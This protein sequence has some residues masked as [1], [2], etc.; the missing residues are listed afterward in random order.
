VL[1]LKRYERHNA[2]SSPITKPARSTFTPFSSFNSAA[3]EHD[4]AELL[5]WASASSPREI[6][7]MLLTTRRRWSINGS[8]RATGRRR[9]RDQRFITRPIAGFYGL[10]IWPRRA[11]NDQC[12]F[13]GG[14][15]AS[16]F[17][18]R[19]ALRVSIGWPRWTA[20]A[21][22]RVM[23]LQR[24]HNDL[25]LLSSVTHPVAVD[26]DPLLHEHASAQDGRHDL[27]PEAK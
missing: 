4:P 21:V 11:G 14:R 23:V 24:L 10:R 9:D 13:T 16:V 20:L 27:A 2:A 7:P 5:A 18:R 1:T 25:P 3:R 6:V 22:H 8:R 17:S 15:L 19:Q 12:R 26:P